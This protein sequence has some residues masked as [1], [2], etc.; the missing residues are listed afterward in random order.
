MSY[1]STSY[2]LINVLKSICQMLKVKYVSPWEKKKIN[3]LKVT[4]MLHFKIPVSGLTDASHAL[5][6]KLMH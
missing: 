6:Q 4:R 1:V 5:K 3:K 2:G